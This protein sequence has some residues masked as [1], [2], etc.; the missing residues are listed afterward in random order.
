MMESA[1]DG[2]DW[3][4]AQAGCTTEVMFERL[5]DGARTDVDRR[6][7]VGGGGS[8]KW[9]FELNVDDDL[10]FEVARVAD[11]SSASAFVTF[12]REGSRINVTGDG[13]DVRFTAITGINPAGEC[14]Y[15]VGEH[16]Y[17]AWE[18][19]KLALDLL[20]FEEVEE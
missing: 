20:F 1:K 8:D 4:T 14:R 9:R 16:E 12:E 7:A 18:V 15:F 6:N 13:V 3:V 11:S 19:R 10:S 5:Q 17:L 2:F